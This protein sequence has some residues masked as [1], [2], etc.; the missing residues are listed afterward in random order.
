MADFATGKHAYGFCE[1]CGFRYPYGELKAEAYKGVPKHNRVCPD[2]WDED[3]PQNF[4]GT[5]VVDDPQ[6]LRRP[7]P[8]VG[9]AEINAFPTIYVQAYGMWMQIQVGEVVVTTT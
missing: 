2:C 6:A 4:V 7:A 1:R 3:H 9:L 5:F 8:D